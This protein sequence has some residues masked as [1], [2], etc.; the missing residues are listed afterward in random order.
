VRVLDHFISYQINRRVLCLQSTLLLNNED[1]DSDHR[2]VTQDLFSWLQPQTFI[3]DEIGKTLSAYHSIRFQ[4]LLVRFQFTKAAVTLPCPIDVQSP[5]VGV[6]RKEC[7]DIT[8][9]QN[10]PVSI[11]AHRLVSKL[12]QLHFIRQ[13]QN[14]VSWYQLV[15]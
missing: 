8:R 5:S 3:E 14:N 12:R 2:Q 7:L 11:T 1:L 4:D 9:A 13:T 15:R 10:E 6:Y